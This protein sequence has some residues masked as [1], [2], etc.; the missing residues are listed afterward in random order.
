MARFEGEPEGDWTLW[1][2]PDLAVG[3]PMDTCAI[4]E[5]LDASQKGAR[6]ICTPNRLGKSQGKWAFNDRG[7]VERPTPTTN[8]E[9]CCVPIEHPPR[10]KIHYMA[11][12]DGHDDL[13]GKQEEEY[14]MDFAH[15]RKQARHGMVAARS[16]YIANTLP[17]ANHCTANDHVP[18]A[19]YPK[20]RPTLLI[21]VAPGLAAPLRRIEETWEAIQEDLYVPQLCVICDMTLFVIQDAAFVLCPDCRTVSAVEG[22]FVDRIAAGVGTGFTYNTLTQ[23]QREIMT[24][25]D[26]IED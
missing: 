14:A 15:R 9:H 16:A 18:G 21:Q 5:P 10:S 6:D 8:E 19:L 17:C 3:L 13:P 2:H 1:S 24:C 22:N 11:F 4:P 26:L 23:W 20:S 25:R 7:A 12:D